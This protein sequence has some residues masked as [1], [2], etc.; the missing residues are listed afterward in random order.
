MRELVQKNARLI[1]VMSLAALFSIAPGSASW[2]ATRTE[3][4]RVH[5]GDRQQVLAVV[6][7]RTHNDKV[8]EKF[9]DK[10]EVLSDRKLQLAVLLCDRIARDGDRLGADIAFSLVTVLVVLS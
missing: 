1:A 7:S 2:A 3:P 8:L 4:G 9:K 10:L 5:A 6:A